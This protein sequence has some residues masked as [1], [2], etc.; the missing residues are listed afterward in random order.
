MMKVATKCQNVGG[1]KPSLLSKYAK[2]SHQHRR[3]Q[4][5]PRYAEMKNE[6]CWRR[7]N[8]II[9]ACPVARGVKASVSLCDNINNMSGDSRNV[10]L[11]HIFLH[12]LSRLHHVISALKPA[13]ECIMGA[14]SGIAVLSCTTL[15][16]T[17]REAHA[18]LDIFWQLA[19]PLQ[20]P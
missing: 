7:R 14:I 18:L 10:D 13:C 5:E 1:I 16:L 11:H 8:R 4:I 6:N 15:A 19:A 12:P 3:N 2:T 20:K 17:Y 9:I